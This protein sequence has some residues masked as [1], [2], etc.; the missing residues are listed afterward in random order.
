MNKKDLTNIEN[1]YVERNNYENKFYSKLTY[2]QRLK[3]HPLLLQI[4]RLKNKLAGFNIKILENNST[5]INRPKIFCITHIGKFDIEVTSEIIKEHYYLLSGDFENIYGTIEEKFLNFNGVVYVREDDKED[6]KLSKTK[7]IDILKNNGNIMYFPEG[8]WNLSPNLPVLKC[9]YGIIDVA[10]KSNAVIIPIAIEQYDKNFLAAIGENFDVSC[11]DYNEKEIAI[12][13][14]RSLMAT[15]KW[16]IWE[17][18]EPN[19]RKNLSNEEFTNFINDRLKEWPN[20]TLDEFLDRVYKPK[21]ITEEK[22]VFKFLKD[23]TLDYNNAFLAK[24]KYNYQ[25]KYINK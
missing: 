15:L 25:K 17:N 12:E 10:M 23:I 9:S 16:K 3:L 19:T 22:E 4:I 14:L 6:R 11:Y 1:Y 21:S 20:F 5:K 2:N 18:I 13:D 8:T 7:M 24:E